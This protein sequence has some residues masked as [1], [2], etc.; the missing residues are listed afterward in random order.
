MQRFSW[1]RGG[2]FFRGVSVMAKIRS[3]RLQLTI[4]IVAITVVL[5]L[6]MGVMNIRSINIY[7][8]QV[9][10][11]GLNWETQRKA[12][13]LDKM[14]LQS[15]DAVDFTGSVAQQYFTRL[16]Q[17]EDP[18][19]RTEV[20]ARLHQRF[21][22]AVRTIPEVDGYYFH[23]NEG[24][25]HGEDGFWYQKN[26]TT[27][28]FEQQPFSHP[29]E[30]P[31]PRSQEKN[32]WYYEPLDRLSPVWI[33]PYRN[34]ENSPLII[35]YTKPI[36]VNRRCI[37]LVGIDIRMDTLIGRLKNVHIYNSGYALLF[38]AG[39]ELYYHPDHPYGLPD[40]NLS[41]FGLSQY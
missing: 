23:F 2:Y 37:G 19:F 3:L 24:L 11:T 41:D 31:D 39:G 6:I 22:A 7:S 13:H 33:S 16:D 40:T 1:L 12:S 18:A 27:G 32:R 35:S 9:A 4:V 29:T 38:S 30:G 34:Q 26:P 36:F 25:V 8:T 17:V 28:Q 20:A 10:N 14:M 15:Q 5:T 21:E